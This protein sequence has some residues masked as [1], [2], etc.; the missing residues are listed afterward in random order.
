[1]SE[2]QYAKARGIFKRFRRGLER[3]PLVLD[4]TLRALVVLI[5]EYD[6]IIFENRFIVGGGTERI[7]AAAM[8]CVG[9]A[10]ARSRGLNLDEEDIIV[11]DVQI[12]VKAS[13]TREKKAIQLINTRGDSVTRWTT[14]TIFVLANVGFGYADPDLLPGIP[15]RVP[16]GVSLRRRPLDAM[17]AQ[18]PEWLLPCAVPAKAKDASQRRAASEAVVADILQ[19]TAGGQPVFPALRQH[20]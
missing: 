15:R 20:L 11:G 3:S 14:P 6:P 9:I 12:S 1:M 13:F 17:H 18:N 4:E 2:E 19:R 5:S 10:N 7:L 8:R 16:D